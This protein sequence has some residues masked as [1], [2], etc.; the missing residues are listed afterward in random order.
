MKTSRDSRLKKYAKTIVERTAEVEKG[1]DVY[2][3]AKSLQ[4]LPLFEE[5]RRQII[6]KGG[7]PH[8]KLLYDSQSGSIKDNDWMKNASKEQL[9]RTSDAELEFM[10]KMDSFISI[11]GLDNQK[12]LSSLSP[13]KISKWGESTKPIQEQRLKKK[14]GLCAYPTDGLAQQSGMS[15]Q[16][17]EKFVLDAVNKTDWEELEEKNRQIKQLFDAA[18]EIRIKDEDTDLRFRLGER[19][20]VSSIGKR[21]MPDGEVFY[22]PITQSFEGKISFSYPVTAHGNEISGIKLVFKDGELTEYTAD[23]N[24]EFLEKMIETDEGSKYIGEFGIGTNRQIDQYIGYT[25]FDEKIGGT[26]HLAL[27]RAYEMCVPEDDSYGRNES[28]VHWDI[29]K[30][31]RERSGGGK[32]IADGKVVQEDGEWKI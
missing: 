1:D 27:G 25:L 12:E 32:I 24:Q 28:S 20:G 2:I 5:V 7:Y 19:K 29:V 22:A 13:E 11:K 30:D 21:N 17:F 8:E 15:T 10:S 31:L 26:I 9:E 14:W 3:V 18:D 6:E 16:K 4:A 23:K